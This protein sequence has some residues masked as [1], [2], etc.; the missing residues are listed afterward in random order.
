MK[1]KPFHHNDL[2]ALVRLQPQGWPD[3]RVN[4]KQYLDFGFCDPYK[5]EINGRIV[6]IG[7]MVCFKQTAWLAHIIVDPEYRNQGLGFDIVTDLISL[8]R[9]NGYQTLS[10]IATDL[11]APVYAK[12]GFVEQTRYLFFTSPMDIQKGQRSTCIHPARP[13][14]ENQILTLDRR[15]SGEDRE[16][17]L[18]HTLATGLVYRTQNRIKGF[19]LPDL[20]EG[21]VVASN[22]IAGLALMEAR[23]I[24]TRQ[25]VIPEQNREGVRFLE[26][27]G[28]H[29]KSTAMRMIYGEPYSFQ[30]DGLFSRV[31]GNFG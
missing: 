17:L 22:D 24:N 23:V 30:P 12:A 10:L 4:F 15:I 31:G 3:I 19:Y 14:D 25:V 5:L 11:G 16:T 1:I 13:R 29:H 26:K 7:A 20:G 6:G 27:R 2:A 18:R 28:F 9:K 8:A 21:L